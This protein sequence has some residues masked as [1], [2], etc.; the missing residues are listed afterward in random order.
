MV[1]IGL[2]RAWR[3]FAEW[4]RLPAHRLRAKM[5]NVAPQHL[6]RQLKE[7]QIGERLLLGLKLQDDDLVFAKPD[8]KHQGSQ[9]RKC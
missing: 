1:G 7:R 6:L 4:K 8:G 2:R 5:K 9:Q 3:Y